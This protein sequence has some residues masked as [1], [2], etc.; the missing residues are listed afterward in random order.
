MNKNVNRNISQGYKKSQFLIFFQRKI[1]Q[2]IFLAKNLYFKNF[3]LKNSFLFLIFFLF[4]FSCKPKIK[5]K[6]EK[7]TPKNPS[8]N[9]TFFLTI[10][11]RDGKNQQKKFSFSLEEGSKFSQKQL[12]KLQKEFLAKNSTG[13]DF[14]GWYAD[15]KFSGEKITAKSL[16]E[17][18]FS[19]AKNFYGKMTIKQ[20]TV[21]FNVDGG[22]GGTGL[23]DPIPNYKT[24]VVVRGLLTE[25]A[26]PWKTNHHFVGWYQDPAKTKKFDFTTVITENKTLYAKYRELE[27]VYKTAT[28][29]IQGLRDKFTNKKFTLVIPEKIYNVKP[30]KFHKNGSFGNDSEDHT[31]K[32]KFT[33]VDLSQLSANFSFGQS[34]FHLNV[35]LEKIT[36]PDGLTEI[37]YEFAKYCWA[38]KSI[39]LP[40]TITSIRD[41][42][43]T[44]CINLEITLSGTTPPTILDPSSFRLNSIGE[45]GSKDK[46]G[47]M[48]KAIRVPNSA[49]NTYRTAKYWK[50]YDDPNSDGDNSDSLFKGY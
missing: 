40:N 49:L 5:D 30:E 7:E 32:N 15:E 20:H 22:K 6:K 41:N 13:Y 50:K 14:N 35:D 38:L 47:G 18:S 34:T 46:F 10:D 48:V 42:A 39:H 44:A 11:N 25:P 16:A 19:K 43:F 12:E 21:T 37:G 8:Y 9:A 29:E 1:F 17:I 31:N 23:S 27:I 26:S 2:R 4:L 45:L 33:N 24:S 3:F 28:K 36:L